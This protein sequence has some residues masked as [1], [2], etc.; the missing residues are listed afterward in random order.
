[1]SNVRDILV[2]AG[3]QEAQIK[4]D[5][6]IALSAQR[7]YAPDVAVFDESGVRAVFE[8]K[9]CKHENRIGI[10]KKQL[11]NLGRIFLFLRPDISFFAVCNDEIAEVVPGDNDLVWYDFGEFEKRFTIPQSSKHEAQVGDF[12]RRIYDA[13]HRLSQGSKDRRIVKFFYRGEN[14][15]GENNKRDMTPSLFRTIHKVAELGMTGN[16]S[17]YEEEEYLVNEAMRTFPAAFSMCKSD[18]DRLTVAQHYG[19]PTRLLDVT[20]NALVALYFAVIEGNDD[21]DG[22]VFVFAATLENFRRASV[23]GQDK[24]LTIKGLHD[25]INGEHLV[26]PALIFPTIQTKRQAAQDGSFYLFP[27]AKGSEPMRGFDKSSYERII[28]PKGEKRKIREQLDHE[29]N[30]RLG[31]LFPES[32][33]G[34]REKIIKEAEERII[35]DAF[36]NLKATIKGER[37]Y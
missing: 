35:I 4:L 37:R 19:I 34:S 22:V 36:C 5:C 23:M 26:Q 20:G 6:H 8:V 24:N 17:Y 29:C 31:T 32:L 9:A 13:Q 25:G 27:S 14:N 2:R 15:L 28:I 21:L 10:L 7:T 16:Y 1:M 18:I 12:L 33:D 30:I 11:K 3:V